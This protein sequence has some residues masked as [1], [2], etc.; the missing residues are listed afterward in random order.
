M[1]LL[2]GLQEDLN[3]I[4]K[5][6]YIEKPDSTDEM[7]HDP[8]ALREMADKCWDIEKA[9]NDSV[10]TDLFA[11]MYKS[12]VVCPVCEKVSI[13]FDPFNNLTLQLPIENLWSRTIIFFPL[14]SRPIKVSVD[15][16][17]NA[18]FKD[19]RE[20]LA[21]KLGIDAR[22]T[23]LAEV[24]KQRFFKMYDDKTTISEEK[25]VDAD[26]VTL[27]ELEDIPTNYPA[28]KK[29]GPRRAMLNYMN[30]DE[31]EDQDLPD[32][33][34]PLADKM[35][36]SIFHRVQRDRS[37]RSP[38]K[39]LFGA[40]SFII[41]DREEA[42]DYDA[43]LKKVLAKV[44]TMTTTDILKDSAQDYDRLDGSVSDLGTSPQ[45]DSDT[46]L[47]NNEDADSS[48]D[49]K[50]QANSVPS[51][52][53]MVDI[54]MK[55]SAETPTMPRI[56]YPPQAASVKSR[57]LPRMLQRGE[58]IEPELRRMFQMNYYS[59]KAMIP[60]CF[61]VMDES[62]TYPDIQSRLPQTK[63]ESKLR[64]KNRNVLTRR[65]QNGGSST[66]SDED[67]PTPDVYGQAEHTAL[68]LNNFEEDGQAES[69]DDGLP[70]VHELANPTQG[71]SR[72]R[73]S[74]PR[75][76]SGL[77]TYSS[78]GKRQSTVEPGDEET[79]VSDTNEKGPLIKLG[80]AILL[81]WNSDA[82]EALF[83]GPEAADDAMRG[84]AT[85]EEIPS[86]PDPELER[87]RQQRSTRRKNGVSLGDCL[88]EFGKAEILS[89]NDAWYCPRC[90]E[91]RRA[92]KKFELWKAPDILVIHLKRFSAQGRL[93]DKLD[94][95]VDF[96]VEGLDLSSRVAIQEEGKSPI[97]DLFAVD[98]HYGGLGGGHYTAYAR[99][100][101]DQ[102]WYEY[103]GKWTVSLLYPFVTTRD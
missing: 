43:I 1:F 86:L 42:A 34:S 13:I 59:G 26:I 44:A 73:K 96:P 78:K 25:I 79:V 20:H 23:V 61:N 97:Y 91:H 74:T 55:E 58:F 60:T 95:F 76:K 49:S 53:G 11:G 50:I 2:D 98:N 68:H 89:E 88:D 31:D 45:E 101:Y 48:S 94:V 57:R 103:N 102:N 8:R 37:S 67:D 47:M 4:H 72:F 71:F 19:L 62:R 22:K 92:S 56:S 14:Y 21:K 75:S 46:V 40:P 5:K 10:I 38:Q 93:R 83:T 81:D 90:K 77:I 35:L 65:I 84:S 17:R 15:I 36:V 39:V 6:P 30:T 9:R 28:P 41:L 64:D 12:T 69:D 99:N 85:W 63:R 24:Y 54:S 7:L 80:E 66:S 33:D 70:P 18:T 87:K 52:D 3:R 16:D 82:Y 27:H 29:K 51:E 32:S 100:F